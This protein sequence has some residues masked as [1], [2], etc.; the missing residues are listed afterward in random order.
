MVAQRQVYDG[1]C[2]QRGVL[3]VEMVEAM[4][5]SAH[6][7]HFWYQNGKLCRDVE[8]GI[9]EIDNDLIHFYIKVNNDEFIEWFIKG[10]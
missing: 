3:K 10:L 7:F 8:R 6:K 4:L 1:I 5:K 9:R 2:C